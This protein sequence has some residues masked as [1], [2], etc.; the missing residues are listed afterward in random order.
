MK[1]TNSVETLTFGVRADVG[2]L[3]SVLYK[4]SYD[5]VEG[6]TVAWSWSRFDNVQ[7]IKVR[8]KQF[9][10][11]V[12]IFPDGFTKWIEASRADKETTYATPKFY[13][14]WKAN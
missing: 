3:W 1:Q 14:K 5:L 6:V 2:R 12:V 11:V 13:I 8:K 9:K 10:K 4:D 7:Q